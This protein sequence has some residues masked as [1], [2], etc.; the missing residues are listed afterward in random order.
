M[1]NRNVDLYLTET[2]LFSPNCLKA[3]ITWSSVIHSPKMPTWVFDKIMM[4]FY[5]KYVTHMDLTTNKQGKSSELQH[6][7]NFK[8]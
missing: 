1:D 8:N 3:P 2:N 4:H 7:N 6:K 5:F